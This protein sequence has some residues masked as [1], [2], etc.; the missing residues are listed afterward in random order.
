MINYQEILELAAK[1]AGIFVTAETWPYRGTPITP[2]NLETYFDPDDLSITGTRVW[3]AFNG[4]I[5]GTEEYTWEPLTD[6]F[7]SFQLM[8]KLHMNIRHLSWLSKD[9]WKI[10]VGHCGEYLVEEACGDDAE[11]AAKLAIVRFAALVGAAMVER[12]TA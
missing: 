12:S 4:E 5:G 8:I 9:S 11:K 1:A 6:E 3:F 10:Q 2:G 7:D